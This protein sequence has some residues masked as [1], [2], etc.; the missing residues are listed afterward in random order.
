M[1]AHMG[2]KE[3]RV[4]P[5]FQKSTRRRLASRELGQGS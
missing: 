5:L 4:P 3:L 1:Q 2:Q